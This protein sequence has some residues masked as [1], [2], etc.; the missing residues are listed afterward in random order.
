MNKYTVISYSDNNEVVNV[1]TTDSIEDA[2]GSFFM[3]SID[4]KL[5]VAFFTIG[6][7]PIQWSSDKITCVEVLNCAQL[8]IE[9]IT[10]IKD[11]S[12]KEVADNIDQYRVKRGYE[13]RY[14][15][16]GF[17]YDIESR[18]KITA[19]IQRA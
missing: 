6:K 11:K 15:S 2:L 9:R 1:F 3:N 16:S 4:R 5:K 14:Y 10:F 19:F 17:V 13:G 8:G 18:T 12:A 7:V